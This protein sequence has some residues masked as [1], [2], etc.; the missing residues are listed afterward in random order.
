[1]REIGVG[2]SALEGPMFDNATE[3]SR[4][5]ETAFTGKPVQTAKIVAA[6]K[7]Y[8]GSTTRHLTAE[9][10]PGKPGYANRGLQT[11]TTRDCPLE[12]TSVDSSASTSH[13]HQPVVAVNAACKKSVDASSSP[14]PI[15]VGQSWGL[16]RSPK[17]WLRCMLGNQKHTLHTR[18]SWADMVSRY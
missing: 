10:L 14:L 2:V 17:P 1:M 5:G 13:L 7:A 15:F 3:P 11:V 18:M 12:D 9:I 16:F 6:E 4:G 8:A